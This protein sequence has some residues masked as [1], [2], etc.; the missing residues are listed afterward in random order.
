MNAVAQKSG[1]SET[2]SKSG[3]SRRPKQAVSAG[4]T[5]EKQTTSSKKST[6]A[7]SNSTGRKPARKKTAGKKKSVAKKATGRKKVTTK[8]KSAT[9]RTGAS[10]KKPAAAT[11]DAR[12]ASLPIDPPPVTFPDAI[13]AADDPKS[14]SWMAQQAVIA[15]NA[16]KAHQAEK[17]KPILARAEKDKQEQDHAASGGQAREAVPVPYAGTGEQASGEAVPVAVG[18]DEAEP[19]SAPVAA[20]KDEPG[21]AEQRQVADDETSAAERS[22]KDHGS[23]NGAPQEVEKQPEIPQKTSMPEPSSV[24]AS[25]PPMAA[26]APVSRGRTAGSP[27]HTTATR[28]YPARLLAVIAIS[29]VV[30][31]WLYLGAGDEAVQVTTQAQP[32]ISGK[33]LPEPAAPPEPVWQPDPAPAQFPEPHPASQ[34]A[35]IPRPPD[36]AVPVVA[37]GEVNGMTAQ[38]NAQSVAA[39]GVTP[40][41][42]LADSAPA[43]PVTPSG[44]RPPGYGYYPRQPA[45]QPPAYYRPGYSRP[46]SR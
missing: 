29:I 46:P 5:P 43:Q 20:G 27:P 1:N 2:K 44:Y 19:V 37:A 35:E 4:D 24:A 10:G 34:A 6:A 8:R 3:K 26:S 39:T 23:G 32:E 36:P 38:E 42:G 7:G 41:H 14:L 13:A 40:A 11:D 33:P 9:R 15:L 18:G 17:G 30:P 45:W 12:L 25:P 31:I 16:V 22:G 21:S 28:R